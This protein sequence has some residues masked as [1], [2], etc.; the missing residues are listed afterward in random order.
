VGIKV[1][2]RK[3]TLITLYRT[4]GNWDIF[5]DWDLVAIMRDIPQPEVDI[6]TMEIGATID[7]SIYE[8]K[9]WQKLLEDHTIWAIPIM[10]YPKVRQIQ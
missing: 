10:H 4:H 3:V 7:V 6:A 9:V 2:L 1:Y 5:S 8:E